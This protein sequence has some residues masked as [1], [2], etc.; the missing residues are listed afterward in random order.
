MCG[1]LGYV[2]KHGPKVGEEFNS[3][4]KY[5]DH[6]GPDSNATFSKDNVAIGFTHLKIV[7]NNNKQPFVLYDGSIALV[8]NGEIYNYRELKAHL[9]KD[10]AVFETDSDCEVIIHLYQKMGLDCFSKIRG[11]FACCIVDFDQSTIHLARDRMGECP[12]YYSKNILEN[13]LVF[14]SEP[15][16]LLSFS[17]IGN[18]LCKQ[19]IY[20]FLCFQFV[21]EPNTIFEDIFAVEPGTVL[22]F[23]INDLD[24]KKL[25]YWSVANYPPS[26]SEQD[27]DA[28]LIQSSNLNFQTSRCPAI[29][30]S[31]GIDSNLLVHLAA[32]NGFRAPLLHLTFDTAQESQIE[33]P[34]AIKTAEHYGYDLETCNL[35]SD[36]VQS[37]FVEIVRSMTQPMGDF[38]YVA[39]YLICELAARYRVRTLHFGHGPDELLW[40]YQWPRMSLKSVK[41]GDERNRYKVFK[42][43]EM[44]QKTQSFLELNTSMRS[45]EFNSFQHS[46]QVNTLPKH[47]AITATLCDTFL[48]SNGLVQLDS[49]SMAHSIEPRLIYMDP[50]F[51]QACFAMHDEFD[52]EQLFDK[53]KLLDKFR[54][55]LPPHLRTVKKRTFS[56]PWRSWQADLLR[57]FGD[58]IN[59]GYLLD[60]QII[61]RSIA[62]TLSK[63]LMVEAYG[64]SLSYRV[65]VLETWLN[66]VASRTGKTFSLDK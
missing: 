31:G 46:N 5:L 61:D 44:F 66:Q 62:S 7:G 54:E 24:V 48:R 11:K 12:L 13:K 16:A 33:T 39:Y 22:S 63:H 52:V 45:D 60:F 47:S 36:Y 19:S 18:R 55:F 41:K 49:V 1:I 3:A 57:I 50:E 59:G 51:V 65:L 6:R 40:G 21:P 35:S 30:V 42:S 15:V 43:N 56:L 25:V 10:G 8:C 26:E 38:T 27:L 2:G 34:N 53:R 29:A 4:L 58:E 20:D 37:N 28:L 14:A 17:N 23:D 32:E 9:V 64:S